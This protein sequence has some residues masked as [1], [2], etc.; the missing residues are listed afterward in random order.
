LQPLGGRQLLPGGSLVAPKRLEYAI[1]SRL[2]EPAHAEPDWTAEH[3]LLAALARCSLTS[4]DFHAK[5]RSIAAQ[6]TASAEGLVTKRDEDGRYAFVEV[7]CQLDID[8]DPPPEPE[9]VEELLDLAERDCFIG[10]SLTAPP[11]YA[12]RVNGEDIR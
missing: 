8:L 1:T 2:G 12:W 3:L 11:H 6:G 5:R 4:L 7:S 9:R 10:A